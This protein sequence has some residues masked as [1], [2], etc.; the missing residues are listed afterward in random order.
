MN[1]IQNK[2]MKNKIKSVEI[3]FYFYEYKIYLLKFLVINK[4]QIKIERKLGLPQFL[5]PLYL[6]YL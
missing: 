6:S 2:L 4:I 1:I 3:K 5:V